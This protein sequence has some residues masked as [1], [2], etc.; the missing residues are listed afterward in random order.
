MT[1]DKKNFLHDKFRCGK[2]CKNRVFTNGKGGGVEY[3]LG[4]YKV[5]CDGENPGDLKSKE[6]RIEIRGGRTISKL[7][8]KF[9]ARF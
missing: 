1:F 7:G 5:R 2:N 4:F 6:I 8:G 9:P 3:G